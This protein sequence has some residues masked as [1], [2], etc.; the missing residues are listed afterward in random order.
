MYITVHSYGV[1]IAYVKQTAIN[2]ERFIGSNQKMLYLDWSRD[3]P[4]NGRCQY[5]SVVTY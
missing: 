5:T 1:V 2:E 3:V 4:V